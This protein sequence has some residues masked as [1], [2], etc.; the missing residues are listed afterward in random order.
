M[1]KNLINII[2]GTSITAMSSGCAVDSKTEENDI[3]KDQG[4]LS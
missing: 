2:F 4:G 3:D 1:N